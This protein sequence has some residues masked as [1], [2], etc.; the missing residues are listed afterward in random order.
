[1]NKK[2]KLKEAMIGF[3]LVLISGCATDVKDKY[4][5]IENLSDSERNQA[6]KDCFDYD[7][8]KSERQDCLLR[9][10]PPE[11]GYECKNVQVSGSRFTERVCSTASKRY[12]ERTMSKETLDKIQRHS[13]SY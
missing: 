7:L 4:A 13:K 2:L 10:A 1:M 8:S 12:Y 9:Y 11:V 5:S 3:V 6:L